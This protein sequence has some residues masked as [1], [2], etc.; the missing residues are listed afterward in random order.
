MSEQF[1]KKKQ[2]AMRLRKLVD[3]RES[4]NARIQVDSAYKEKYELL[5]KRYQEIEKVYDFQKSIIQKMGS[6]LFT[7]D[8]NGSITFANQAS[9][10]TLGYTYDEVKSKD[11]KDFFVEAKEAEEVI[12]KI[13]KDHIAFESYETY[14]ISKKGEP[15]PIGFSTSYIKMD[16]REDSEGVLFLFRNITQVNNLRRQIERMDRLATL[17][18]LS[19]GI[20]HEIRNPLAGIKTSAQVLEESFSPGDFRSQLVSRIVKEID[21]SNELLKKFFNF[22]KPSKPKQEFQNIEMIIDGVY[23]LL[24]SRLR[25]KNILFKTDFAESIPQVYI[26]S[27]QIEQVILNV[28]L[29]AVEAITNGG[30]IHV[31]ISI[32]K[33]VKL[34]EDSAPSDAVCIGI[35]DDGVGIPD[36]KLEKVFNP[37]FTTKSDGV[38]LGLSIS[39]RLLEE[40]GGKIELESEEGTGTLFRIYLPIIANT[41]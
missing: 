35:A 17:G 12:K 24:A 28:F 8:M 32:A 2:T 41:I 39:S 15:V 31:K 40:N 30:E 6:G 20:A 3:D 9:L 34:K 27:S 4:L 33:H 38:G 21:R 29:N 25:K 37:F 23:L 16:T 11:I 14:W 10:K 7:I 1:E 19:A 13:L 36:E 22:A 26:D 5:L 18:E